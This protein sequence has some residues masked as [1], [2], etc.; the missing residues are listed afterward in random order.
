MGIRRSEPIVAIRPVIVPAKAR[1]VVL[2]ACVTDRSARLR[3][4]AADYLAKTGPEPATG[5]FVAILRG[6]PRPAVRFRM[7]YFEKCWPDTAKTDAIKK[8]DA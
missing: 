3:L 7:S 6:D 5:P 4:L 1:M 2:S 8:E